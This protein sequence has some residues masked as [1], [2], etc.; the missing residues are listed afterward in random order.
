APVCGVVILPQGAV[1]DQVLLSLGACDSA[2]SGCGSAAGSVVQTLADLT[3][4]YSKDAPAAMLVKCDKSLCGSGS[5][6]SKR[7]S[8][9]LK[10]NDSLAPAEA[11]P[12]KGTVGSEPAC[13]DYV[14]SKRDGSGDTF[15]YLLFTKDARVS[16]G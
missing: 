10:G 15:L 1:S 2:Y 6:Q 12:A 7:L 9:S 14:Q 13:V 3:D 8:Y 4:R 5:I 16:V 11:C